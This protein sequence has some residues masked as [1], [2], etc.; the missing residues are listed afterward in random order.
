M[1]R[2]APVL[3]CCRVGRREIGL[4]R[5]GRDFQHKR[6]VSRAA[7]HPQLAEGSLT[8][9][10]HLRGEGARVRKLLHRDTSLRHGVGR[11]VAT[12]TTR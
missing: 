2:I 3:S 5:A 4:G 1:K 8:Q 12:G 6:R 7:L 9:E 10:L 11:A